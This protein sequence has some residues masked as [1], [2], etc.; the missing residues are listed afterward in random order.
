MK[1]FTVSGKLYSGSS[2]KVRN[3]ESCSHQLQYFSVPI[4][5]LAQAVLLVLLPGPTLA[6]SSSHYPRLPFIKLRR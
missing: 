1:V 6:L 5:N 3:E 2:L 4:G